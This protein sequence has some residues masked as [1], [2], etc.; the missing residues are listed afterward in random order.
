MAKFCP[1][2]GTPYEEPATFC[3]GCGNALSAPAASTASSNNEVVKTVKQYLKVIIAVV[4][5]FAL[6]IGIMNLFGMYDVSASAEVFGQK[7]NNEAPLS[8]LREDAPDE[9]M[10]FILSGYA[11]GLVGLAV[12]GL[13]GYSFYLVHTN[14]AGSKLV[15]QQT[16]VDRIY[17][18]GTGA[19][20]ENGMSTMGNGANMVFKAPL[21]VAATGFLMWFPVLLVLL[22]PGYFYILVMVFVVAYFLLAALVITILM[23]QPLLDCLLAA[24]ADGTL[25]REE[26]K[27]EEENNQE[28]P[29]ENA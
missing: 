22:L 17:T 25:L 14:A 26:E 29:E 9:A 15:L 6:L 13:A 8:D 2:C 10:A 23:K 11:L 7:V 1:K 21:Q 3:T 4:A 20:D 24:R 12:A 18:G 5:A 16:P 19:E 27:E 28:R